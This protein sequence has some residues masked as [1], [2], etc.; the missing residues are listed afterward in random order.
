MQVRLGTIVLTSFLAL[1]VT[2]VAVLASSYVGAYNLGNR[3]EQS[4]EAALLH[5]KNVLSTY[6]L[7]IKEA[8][9]VPEKYVEALE[10]VVKTALESRYGEQGSKAMFQF[11]Q[12]QN[13]NVDPG[14]YAKLQQIIEAGR[15]DFKVAQDELI[16]KKRIYQTALGSFWTGMWLRITGYPKIDLA[17][18]KILTDATTDAAYEKGQQEEIKY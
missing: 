2:L 10:K 4:L 5:N 17:S 1:T 12:E 3:S 9:H 16:D 11:I 6:T 15:T 14:L 18:I 13:P 7:K 8:A